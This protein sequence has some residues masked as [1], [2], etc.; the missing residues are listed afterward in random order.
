M[1]TVKMIGTTLLMFFCLSAKAHPGVGIVMDRQGNVFYT[2]LVNVW[3]IDPSGKK[4]LAVRGV[5]THELFLDSQGNLFGEHLW[6]TGE[7]LN[8][9]GHF[10]WKR[11]P[12]GQY[13]KITPDTEGF[14][15][16]Y[17]FV[18]DHFGNMYVA[19]RDTAC[20]MIY[21]ISPRQQRKKVSPVCLTHVS[22]MY[23]NAQGEIVFTDDKK[24]KQLTK[25]GVRTIASLSNGAM[26]VW[27]D[28]E[29]N[30]YA[31]CYVDRQ[32][33]KFTKDGRVIVVATTHSDWYPSGGLIGPDGACWILENNSRN[34]VRVEKIQANG[35]R[36]T[37]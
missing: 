35:H 2:D 12:H 31:A 14:L 20:Q 19:D 4:T 1:K 21:Q 17:S 26:G 13:Q 15:T 9:W 8:T 33:K 25:R 36:I 3:K 28:A 23:A 5:H 7:R 29:G 30:L 10:V 11:T 24:L 22:W 16:D 6:Y 34:E 18:R 32:V 37:F 27:D